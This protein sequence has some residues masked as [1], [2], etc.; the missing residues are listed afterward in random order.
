VV[1]QT[2]ILVWFVA[3]VLLAT[4]AV[5]AGLATA[6]Q[7][8]SESADWPT[9]YSWDLRGAGES[10]LP[11]PAVA[12]AAAAVEPDPLVQLIVYQVD[13]D[14]VRAYDGG[15]SGEW[16]VMVEGSL[17][18]ITQR[19]TCSGTP[20]YKA[21]RYVGEHLNSLGLDVQYQEWTRPGFS[22][23]SSAPSTYPNVIG[24]LQGEV[25]PDDI[26]II[27]AHLDAVQ[28]APG[29]DDNATGSAAV[30]IA[31]DSLSQYQWGCTLRFAV[32]TGEEQGMLGSDAY[33]QQVYDSGENI[34]GVL[35]LDMIGYNT[36]S[37]SPD[38]EFHAK[39][40][41]PSTLQ[42][43]QLA[44]D[45]VDAY[46][47]NLVPE[48]VPNG[49]GASDHSSFWNKG[50]PAILG[51]EDHSVDFNPYYHGS[52]DD[53]D[54]LDLAYFTEYVKAAVAIFAHMTGCLIGPQPY[55]TYL[56]MVAK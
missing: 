48:I 4:L 43:A 53:L 11:W 7:P 26:Y 28:G 19:Y 52:D 55:F 44:A 3:A 18:T 13:Q 42:L 8:A 12:S 29:A 33:A 15:L 10:A 23:P 32:W 25:N 34:L 5:P 37:S 38:I 31:A 41:M 49:I 9:N 2:R 51:I 35:N 56:P 36:A 22:C 14:T 50:Y 21:T 40:S 16:P 45:V 6:S 27:S 46:D 1:R 54:N 39:S 17:Y 30:M 24:E 47:L 20:I